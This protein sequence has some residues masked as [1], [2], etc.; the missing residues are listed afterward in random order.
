MDNNAQG[1]VPPLNF[2]LKDTETL[3]CE[4]CGCEVFEEKMMIKRMSRFMTGSDKDSITPIPVIVCASCNH[5]NEIFK[6]QI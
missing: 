1:G 2:N 6:P 3:K 4:S 5:I